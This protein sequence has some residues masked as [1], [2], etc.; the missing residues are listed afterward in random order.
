MPT[1]TRRS[2]L[3]LLAATPVAGLA[4][5]LATEAPAA[6]GPARRPDGDVVVRDLTVPV[7]GLPAVPAYL[8][9]P[10]RPVP[11]HR[12]PAVLFL[13]WFDPRATNGDRT[14]FVAEAVRLA[15]RGV[16]SLLP[17]QGFPWTGDPVGDARDVAAI[18]AELTRLRHALDALLA[19][20]EVDG[21]RV[22]VVGHDYGAMYG[23]LLAAGD[24][25]V[26]ALAAL[27]PDA[28]WESWFLAYWLGYEGPAAEA[29]AR[30]F[31]AVQPVDAMGAVATERPVL[32][33]FADDDQ[34]VDAA[35]R[36]RFA[37][38]APAARLEVYRRA[39]HHLDLAALAD[40]TAWLDRVLRL[41]G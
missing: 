38:A 25:R 2:V 39:G 12:A 18:E 28:A 7:R 8:V 37:A 30:L 22:A 35:V 40:R 32:L 31:A 13:H 41:P 1:P 20:P 5:A 29:Y 33:Q 6:A 27:A 17:Q 3:G 11:R 16:V 14:E 36:A 10:A 9:R 4:T 15:A 26:S 24:R 23:A 19:R 21:R 34:Y